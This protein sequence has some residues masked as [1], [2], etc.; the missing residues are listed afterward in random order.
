[1]QCRRGCTGCVWNG[2]DEVEMRHHTLRHK[3]RKEICKILDIDFDNEEITLWLWLRVLF[4][5]IEFVRTPEYGGTLVQ[6]VFDNVNK[7]DIYGF[8]ETRVEFFDEA[9][10]EAE[11]G[12]SQEEAESGEVENTVIFHPHKGMKVLAERPDKFLHYATIV[13]LLLRDGEEYVKVRWAATHKIE[14][15]PC[16]SI[17]VYWHK[18]DKAGTLGSD[19]DNTL[20]DT[21]NEYFEKW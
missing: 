6:A 10:E 14:I 8:D 12:D 3:A 4:P 18:R 2:G 13:D 7:R 20:P 11:S 21:P 16:L 15:I 5:G 19:E 17:F 1:M 9:H